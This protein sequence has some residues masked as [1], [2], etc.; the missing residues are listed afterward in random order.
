MST[1]LHSAKDL[2]LL[3]SSHFSVQNLARSSGFLGPSS[4]PNARCEVRV[5]R[6]VLL[7]WRIIFD[8]WEDALR[9]VPCCAESP[10]TVRAIEWDLFPIGE[11]GVS[12]VDTSYSTLPATNEPNN[13]LPVFEPRTDVHPSC[14]FEHVQG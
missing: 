9:A 13:S 1:Q 6:D 4:V 2:P 8:L 3:G 7:T 5:G 14:S 11:S 12:R 10:T